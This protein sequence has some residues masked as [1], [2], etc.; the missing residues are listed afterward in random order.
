MGCLNS[1]NVEVIFNPGYD[2]EYSTNVQFSN[3]IFIFVSVPQKSS[4]GYL[5]FFYLIIFHPT[6]HL[7]NILSFYNHWVDSS[8]GL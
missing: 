6:I 5:T 4:R 8:K 2:D 1:N 3:I 7:L